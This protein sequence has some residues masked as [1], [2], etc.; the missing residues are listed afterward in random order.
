MAFIQTLPIDL[1]I[2]F[3]GD[4]LMY[5]EFVVTIRLMAGREHF[6]AM[7]RLWRGWPGSRYVDRER[8]S[9]FRSRGST[10]RANGAS[11]RAQQGLAVI[12]IDPTMPRAPG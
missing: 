1:A 3:A 5:L 10:A 4:T 7:L 2:L 8:P 12:Q 11:P 9:M 6:Q